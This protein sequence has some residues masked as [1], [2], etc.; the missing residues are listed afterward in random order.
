MSELKVGDRIRVKTNWMTIRTPKWMNN[1]VGTVKKLNS[2]T[3]TVVL[4]AYPDETH[5]IDYGDYEEEN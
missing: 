5:R 3:I 2:K 4:D 1:Y